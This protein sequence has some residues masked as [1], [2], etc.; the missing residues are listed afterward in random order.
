MKKSKFT[1][2]QFVQDLEDCSTQD[3]AEII[4]HV[5][6]KFATTRKQDVWSFFESKIGETVRFINPI[7]LIDE[8]GCVDMVET[9]EIVSILTP[10][11]DQDELEDDFEGEVV[12]VDVDPFN[13]RAYRY[14]PKFLLRH[15]IPAH[16]ESVT[17]GDDNV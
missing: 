17:G 6:V 2:D 11:L 7:F 13:F 3:F 15:I 9:A 12:L 14:P 10:T 8:S 4:A 5:N 16:S 1:V